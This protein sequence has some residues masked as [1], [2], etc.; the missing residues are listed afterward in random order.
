M[1]TKPNETVDPLRD[2]DLE[3]V[4][5]ETAHRARIVVAAH[6]ADPDQ[7]TMLLN[8]LGIGPDSADLVASESEES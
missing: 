2:D 5:D 1:A 4:A 3:P 6:S 7:C 8:M